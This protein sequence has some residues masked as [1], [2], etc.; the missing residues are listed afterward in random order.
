MKNKTVQHPYFNEGWATG[1]A[2]NGVEGKALE[3]AVGFV[4]RFK[5]DD[6]LPCLD[7]G[8]PHPVYITTDESGQSINMAS[9]GEVCLFFFET[10]KEFRLLIISK[11]MMQME[12]DLLLE[13]LVKVDTSTG[14]PH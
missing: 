14:V 1:Y 13:V 12:M 4:Y 10:T 2:I 9:I 8:S 3:L 6:T 11:N 5:T 7:K